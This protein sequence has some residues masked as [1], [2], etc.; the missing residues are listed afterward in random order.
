VALRQRSITEPIRSRSA[1][2]PAISRVEL[3][4]SLLGLRHGVILPTLNYETPDPEC[5]LNVVA[6]KPRETTNRT[7]LKVNVTR[8][9]QA[10]AVVI[11]V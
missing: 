4:A 11:G 8:M 2:V 5:P 6:G 1:A 10:S 3:A 9:G 7:F